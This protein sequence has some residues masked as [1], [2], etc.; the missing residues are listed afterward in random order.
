MDLRIPVDYVFVLRCLAYLFLYN[1]C[2]VIG[3]IKFTQHYAP[4]K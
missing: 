3:E 2:D 4:K 1:V